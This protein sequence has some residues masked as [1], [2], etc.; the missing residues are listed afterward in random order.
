M[1]DDNTG[2]GELVHEIALLSDNYTPP[3]DA[4]QTYQ[5]LYAQLKEFQDD[6]HAHI[7]LEHNILF[8]GV[9]RLEKELRD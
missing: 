8:P 3:S 2:A 7:H 6:L 4:C 1:E 9:M 5:D